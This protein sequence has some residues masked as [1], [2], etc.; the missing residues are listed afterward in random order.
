[1]SVAV[2]AVLAAVLTATLT[3]ALGLNRQAQQQLGTATQAQQL[4]EQVRG[5]SSQAYGE[6]YERHVAA[7]YNMARQVADLVEPI[8]RKYIEIGSRGESAK[9]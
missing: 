7:A 1:M 3:G 2:L 8:T 5:G 6:L 9:I 4:L